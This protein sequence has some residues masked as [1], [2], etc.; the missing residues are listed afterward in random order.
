[1]LLPTQRQQEY[2][3]PS[4]FIRISY[5]YCKMSRWR[6]VRS[7]FGFGAGFGQGIITRSSE[8]R[9][10]PGSRGVVLAAIRVHL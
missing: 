7:A 6:Y 4:L 10:Y 2:R 1:M 5:S 8:F 9:V 3:I